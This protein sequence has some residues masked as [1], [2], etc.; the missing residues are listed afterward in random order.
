MC[1]EREKQRETDGKTRERERPT[2]THTHTH[3]RATF[4]HALI[5]GAAA[6]ATGNVGLATTAYP[7]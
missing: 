7:A 3:T 1:R 4:L 5:T 6:A 2:H